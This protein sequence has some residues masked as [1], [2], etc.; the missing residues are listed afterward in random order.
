MVFHERPCRVSRSLESEALVDVLNG[1]VKV[2]VH[3][4]EVT[5]FDALV[6]LTSEFEYAFHSIG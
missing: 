2:N 6:R 5:N 4:Y 1:K 3:S